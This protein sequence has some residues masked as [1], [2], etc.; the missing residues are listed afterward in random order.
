MEGSLSRFF[1][2]LLSFNHSFI[3]FHSFV[4]LTSFHYLFHPFSHFLFS[5]V[6]LCLLFLTL[7]SLAFS[8]SPLYVSFPLYFPPSLCFCVFISS[9][10]SSFQS[11][12]FF[13]FFL[14]IFLSSSSLSFFMSILSASLSSLPFY[15][16]PSLIH[17]FNRFFFS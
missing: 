17:S 15:L 7:I 14:I 8:V 9:F 13:H 2:S 10:N 1:F 11:L 5:S 3:R 16:P 6:Y 12:F 4:F